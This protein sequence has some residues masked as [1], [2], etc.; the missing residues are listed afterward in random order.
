MGSCCQGAYERDAE[1][2]CEDVA[3]RLRAMAVK[4]PRPMEACICHAN[5]GTRA[6]QQ[7][8]FP[9]TN[10]PGQDWTTAEW[11]ARGKMRIEEGAPPGAPSAASGCL[12][13]TSV[14]FLLG[15]QPHR[16]GKYR[17]RAVAQRAG[18][19]PGI[20]N[21]LAPEERAGNRNLVGEAVGACIGATGNLSRRIA[22]GEVDAGT[23]LSLR[24]QG[25]HVPSECD[26]PAA[27]QIAGKGGIGLDIGPRQV[28]DH[29]WRGIANLPGERNR[30]ACWKRTRSEE[31][32]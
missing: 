26:R 7:R 14:R 25:G 20:G 5:S 21:H 11:T 28:A 16:R 30:R 8:F 29:K 10:L 12:Q 27:S 6:R 31:H 32:T 22:S 1:A 23:C 19:G 13:L 24:L 2:R 17:S 18:G 9:G 4:F 15:G 3:L